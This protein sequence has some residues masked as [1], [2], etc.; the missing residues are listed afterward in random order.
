[1]RAKKIIDVK[2]NRIL[3]LNRKLLEEMASGMKI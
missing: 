2:K 3:I 1:M